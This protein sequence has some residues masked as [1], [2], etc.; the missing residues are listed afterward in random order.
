[1]V[2]MSLLNRLHH[3]VH[4]WWI[5]CQARSPFEESASR[6]APSHPAALEVFRQSKR[7][8]LLQKLSRLQMWDRSV[9]THRCSKEDHAMLTRAVSEVSWSFPAALC[10]RADH[11]C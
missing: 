8:A 5:Q 9:S 3:Q 2:Q 11:R 7:L 4:C 1:M 6:D 10:L